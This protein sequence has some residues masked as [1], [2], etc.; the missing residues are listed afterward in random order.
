MPSFGV[1]PFQVIVVVSDRDQLLIKSSYEEGTRVAVVR[2]VKILR[3]LDRY[4]SR[5]VSDAVLDIFSVMAMDERA[6]LSRL[7]LKNVS[8]PEP[9]MAGSWSGLSFVRHRTENGAPHIIEVRL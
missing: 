2:A 3:S 6:S 7:V 5:A 9:N 1:I 4:C 8:I